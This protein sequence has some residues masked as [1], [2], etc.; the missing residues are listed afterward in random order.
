[1]R[2]AF[3]GLPNPE[4]AFSPASFEV[5][6]IPTATHVQNLLD[7]VPRC[8]RSAGFYTTPAALEH[9]RA[10]PMRGSSPPAITEYFALARSSPAARRSQACPRSLK[11]LAQRH[12][13]STRKK[14]LA[15]L[16]RQGWGVL[17]A[18][19]KLAPM[20][21]TRLLFRCV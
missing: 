18:E 19:A 7:Y 21:E 6:G 20:S 15:F 17:F 3:S 10:R 5:E 1:M 12:Y 9:A 11:G 14:A 4:F 8:R 13:R 16:D 2:D